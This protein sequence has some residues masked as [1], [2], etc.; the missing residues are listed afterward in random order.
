MRDKALNY[1]EQ[2]KQRQYTKHYVGK[3]LLRLK[4]FSL[5]YV[6][7][8][9]ST[10]FTQQIRAATTNRLKRSI[11]K[12]VGNEFHNQFVVSRDVVTF[13]YY[14]FKPFVQNQNQN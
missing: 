14:F 1:I 8:L 6:E 4:S 10:D 2:G 9:P 12:R 13:D 5:E 7:N 3:A 11:T